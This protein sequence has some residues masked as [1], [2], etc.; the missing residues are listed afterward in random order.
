MDT[1]AKPN[2]AFVGLVVIVIILI[3]GGVYFWQTKLKNTLDQQQNA[4]TASQAITSD[5]MNDLENLN[6][7]TGS[8]D[9][10]TG[11]DVNTLK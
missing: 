4:A 5:D 7:E 9:T 6:T 1:D 2:G 8:L 11:V 3:I 10:T